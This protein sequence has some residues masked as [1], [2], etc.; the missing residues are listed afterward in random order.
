MLEI[1]NKMS[2]IKSDILVLGAGVA[3]LTTAIKLAKA[4]PER[5]I[6][7]AT[8]A[9]KEESNTKY[10]QGGIAAVWDEDDTFESHIQDTLKAGD[11]ENNEEVVKIVVENA[12]ERLNELIKWEPIL[13]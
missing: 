5:K 6:I 4:L 10:A 1:S 8:K 2:T 12:P 7:V 3:G 13:I 9:N 11:F